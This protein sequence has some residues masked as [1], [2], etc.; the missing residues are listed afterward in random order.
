[1][2]GIVHVMNQSKGDDEYE[3]VFCYL[4]SLFPWCKVNGYGDTEQRCF[5]EGDKNTTLDYKKRV[6]EVT[7]KRLIFEKVALE[8][9]PSNSK[10]LD[11]LHHIHSDGSFSEVRE[12]LFKGNRIKEREIDRLSLDDFCRKYRVRMRFVDNTF[13]GT[14]H[15][16]KIGEQKGDGLE[17]KGWGLRWCRLEDGNRVAKD[18]DGK[19]GFVGCIFEGSAIQGATIAILEKTEVRGR[20]T[21]EDCLIEK[22]DFSFRGYV[23]EDYALVEFLGRNEIKN[24][25]NMRSITVKFLRHPDQGDEKESAGDSWF[26]EERDRNVDS[27]HLSRETAIGTEE[28]PL[29][30]SRFFEQMVRFQSEMGNPVQASLAHHKHL[31]QEAHLDTL[32]TQDKWMI[33]VSGWFG[34]GFDYVKPLKILFGSFSAYALVAY[35]LTGYFVGTTA[36]FPGFPHVVLSNVEYANWWGELII[37]ALLVLYYPIMVIC[38]YF[39]VRSL[40]RFGYKR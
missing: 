5:S 2:V 35:C 39:I 24:V 9:E 21:F 22:T 36:L 3:N 32:E 10:D 6:V 34:G 25:L 26:S 4:D 8:D 40:L 23:H 7:G 37:Q 28:S 15:G 18:E 14:V 20:L 27:L 30:R 12:I 1:M 17:G 33:R 19:I 16:F 29:D 31:Q 13:V 38:W 11:R